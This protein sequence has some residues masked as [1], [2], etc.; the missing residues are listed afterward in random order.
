MYQ[1]LALAPLK[2]PPTRGGLKIRTVNLMNIAAFKALAPTR[3]RMLFA[4][5]HIFCRKPAPR[6]A[7]GEQSDQRQFIISKIF[8]SGSSLD[9]NPR[10]F[11]LLVVIGP[12]PEFDGLSGVPAARQFICNKQRVTI[13]GKTWFKISA[14]LIDG[15]EEVGGK[16]KY[17]I[18]D[19][20]SLCEGCIR[21][22]VVLYVC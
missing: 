11:P 4:E 19:R 21:G 3:S 16:P 14:K 5:V 18:S 8:R 17:P 9:A 13:E 12:K 20:K 1:I 7:Q 6:D 2:P 22:T 10:L 15:T